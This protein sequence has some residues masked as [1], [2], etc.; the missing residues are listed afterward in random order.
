MSV[1]SPGVGAGGLASLANY[2]SGSF[3]ASLTGCT[4]VPTGTITYTIY[5]NM[6]TLAIPSISGTSNTTAATLTG[7]PAALIPAQ[8]QRLLA[9]ITDNGTIAAGIARIDNAGGTITMFPSAAGG[10][11]TASGTKGIA[12]N[13]LTYSLVGG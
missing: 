4:T 5:G 9:G 12:Q 6:V 13:T 3:T 2:S 11:F 7:L 8:N 10:A 1:K